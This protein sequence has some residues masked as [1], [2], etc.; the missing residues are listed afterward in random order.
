MKL[1][2]RYLLGTILVGTLAGIAPASWASSHREAPAIAGM[3]RVDATDFYM[4]RSYE[5]GRADYVTLI[6]NYLPDQSPYGGPNYYKLD[7]DAIYEIHIDNDGDAKEDLTFQ[8]NFD[9]ALVEGGNGKTYNVGGVSV[10]GPLR[11][12]GAIAAPADA[13]INETE[14]YTL[15]VI[16]GDRRK[17]T[18]KSNVT[19]EGSTATQFVKP[20]DN[21]GLKTLPNYADYAD[22]HIYP[23]SVPIPGCTTP[24]K[25]FVGQ[26]EEAFAVN[27]GE[28]FD[29]V[30][31][32]P[33]QGASNAAYPQYNTATPFPGGIT[34]SRA[35]ND[36]DDKN[37][38]SIALEL[39]ISCLTGEGNG[40]IGG[41]TTASLP[42]AQLRDPSPTYNGT[43]RQGGAMV[44]VSRLSAPLVNEVVIG[45]KDKDLFNAARPTIDTALATYV[46]NPVLP[47]LL[48]ALFPGAAIAPNN[49]P[50]NDLVAAFLTGFENVNQLETVT[51]SEMMRL[52]T[53]IPATARADQHTFG[54]VAED[55]AGFPNGRRPGDDVVDIA[56]R[57]MMGALCH[58]LPLGAELGVTGAVEGE[59]SDSVNLGLCT[60]EDAP[61]G[62][63]PFT[64]GAPLRAPE[65]QNAFPYLNTPIPGSP[66]NEG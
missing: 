27:L 24:G 55:L 5:P 62:T 31:L 10:A 16:S 30:N 63:T 46:T 8:F 7:N 2:S 34:Q 13:N 35:N 15:R 1:K 17:G 37:V 6:A 19:L 18:P 14:S 21:I 32:V 44:Q 59:E 25:V 29:L 28:I 48:E 3:P 58:P 64:D 23:I 20:I 40:V 33:V 42:Q 49:F 66:N 38:T 53:G 56:L 12:A 51:G 50:R 22:K 54:L 61:S 57:V 4:F 41:W 45:L 43:T 26:R 39:P 36:L 52:N 11:Q 65:L 9:S 47:E 60:P